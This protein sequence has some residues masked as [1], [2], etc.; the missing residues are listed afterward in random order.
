MSLRKKSKVTLQGLL[1]CFLP[2]ES[3]AYILDPTRLV[4]SGLGTISMINNLIRER[5]FFAP[6]Q[7]VKLT[8]FAQRP[9]RLSVK[10]ALVALYMIHVVPD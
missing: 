6:L 5:K 3:V 2:S 10:P 8:N 4:T 7:G 1:L 9:D